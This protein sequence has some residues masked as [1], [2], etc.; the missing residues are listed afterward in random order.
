MS[1]SISVRLA[2]AI[3]LAVIVAVTPLVAACTSIDT[4]PTPPK[5]TI[6]TPESC[7]ETSPLIPFDERQPDKQKST[8]SQLAEV[9]LKSAT[10]VHQPSAVN[11][12][13]VGV[14]DATNN[15]GVSY[16]VNFDN[17]YLYNN[18]G[19]LV[20]TP[21]DFKKPD[22]VLPAEALTELREAINQYQVLEWPF[23]EP[24]ESVND[25][26]YTVRDGFELAVIFYD[27]SSSYAERPEKSDSDMIG[28]LNWSK[29]FLA[30]QLD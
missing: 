2:R 3:A 10:C 13:A 7:T 15:S 5:G 8:W 6:M 16:A 29:T 9:T 26:E 21:A 1:K 22:V 25:G 20:F 23:R 11:L 24:G 14:S 28:F 27:D 4:E 19:V 18:I 12:F 30:E 17:G